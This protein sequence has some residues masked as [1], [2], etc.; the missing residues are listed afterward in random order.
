M[1][2]EDYKRNGIAC[3]SEHRRV[4]WK[5]MRMLTRVLFW[6]RLKAHL[7][8]E[9]ALVLTL[10][11]VL[12]LGN[13]LSLQLLRVFAQS[14]CSSGDLS[15][16]VVQGDTLSGIAARFH[17]SWW[18]LASYNHLVNAN[19]IFSTQTICIPTSA[20]GP[21]TAIVPSNGAYVA[22]A[23]D[24]ALTTGLSPDLFVRQIAQESGF[25]PYA[26]SPAG[27]LGIAQF[28]PATAAQLGVNPRNPTQA[29]LGAARLMAH[30]VRQYGGDYA[31]ALAAYNAGPG[32][33]QRAVQVGGLNWRVY[34]PAETQNYIRIILGH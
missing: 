8:T 29:L 26:I 3:V 20:S 6:Q 17:T 18:R 21:L 33:V 10:L 1:D 5:D 11:G 12:L 25:D 30:Y 14:P 24:D 7:A 2:A 9:H 15:Y 4:P 34:L 32:A 23:R 13:V 31:M 22:L 16:S 19:L 28:E 27:A